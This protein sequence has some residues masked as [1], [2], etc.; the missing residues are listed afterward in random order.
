MKLSKISIPNILAGIL[1]L[2]V[3]AQW[4]D[5]LKQFSNPKETRLVTRACG[6]AF[7]HLFYTSNQLGTAVFGQQPQQGEGLYGLVRRHAKHLFRFVPAD[8]MMK[9]KDFPKSKSLFL[10]KKRKKNF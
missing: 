7:L 9:V 4:H 10:L 1:L 8:G 2:Q 6:D 5:N 3:I